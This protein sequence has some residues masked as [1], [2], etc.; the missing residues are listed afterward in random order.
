MKRLQL[1]FLLLLA[2]PIGMLAQSSNKDNEPNGTWQQASEIT[3]GSTVTGRL[4]DN[5]DN[6][7]WYKIVVPDE[8]IV[9]FKQHSETNL[10]LG[11]LYVEALDS[12]GELHT[13]GSHDMD[14]RGEDKDVEFSINDMAPGT[15]YI[16]QRHYTGNGS[17]QLTYTF[18]PNALQADKEPND[19][20]EKGDLLTSGKMVEGR[21]GYYYYND[22]D[23]VDCYKIVVPDEGIVTI[24]QHSE[25][26]LR[27]GTLY[28][29]ALDNGG[30][31]HT[32][33]SHD[34]DGRGEDKDV[35]FSIN[36]MAPGTYY[37]TQKHYTGY[38]GYQLTYTFTPNAHGA[39]VTGNDSYDKAS[40][41]ESGI[42][43]QGRLGYYYH[44]D[45]DNTDWYRIEVPYPSEAIFSTKT[46][47]T[48]RLGTMYVNAL[49]TDG[50]LRSHGSKDMDG[51]GEDT[52]IVNTISDL[53]AG[54]YYI[55]LKR[56]TGYGGYML[57]YQ[58]RPNNYGRDN[59]NNTSFS[60][61]MTLKE[62]T[63][64]NNTLGYYYYDDTNTEDWYDLGMI[65]SK[66][67]DVTISPE[68]SR[69]L[70][71]STCYIYKY[72]GDNSDGSPKLE[73]VASARLERS[74][75]TLSYIDKETT[76]SHY[77]V[78]VVRYN[79]FGGYSICYGKSGGESEAGAGGSNI[80]VMTGGHNTVRKGVPC[81]NPITISNLSDQPSD[82]FMLAID[83][84]DNINIIGFKM[85]V[86]NS[87]IYLP[88]DSVTIPDDKMCVFFVPRLEPWESYTF[89]LISEGVGDIAYAPQHIGIQSIGSKRIVIAGT[90]ITV[91]AIGAFAK[92]AAIS[93]AVGAAVDWVSKKAGDAIF[94]ADSEDAQN[95]ARLMGTTT[96]QLGIRS[97]W[98]SPTVYTAKSVLSTATTEYTKKIV[99]KT[100]TVLDVVGNVITAL[101]NIIPNLR[102][103]IWSWI[104]KDLG[105]YDNPSV[106]D[107]KNA[108]TDVVSSWDPNEMVGPAGAGDNHY[109]GKTQTI[110]YR[111][112]FENKAEA[113]APAY[114]VRINDEL[115]EKV[116]DVS[117]VKFGGTSH[118]GVGYNWKMTREGNRITWDIEGIEL[119]PNVNA[120]E[121]EGYVSFS[122]DLKSGLKD[123]TQIKNKATIIFDKNSPIETNEYVNILD[124][125][126]PTTTMNLA[127]VQESNTAHITCKSSD[128]GSGVDYYL[129]FAA[130]GNG[131]YEYQGQYFT[132]EMDCTVDGNPA[133]YSFYALAVDAVGNMEKTAPQAITPTGIQIIS[134]NKIPKLKVYSLDGRYVGKSLIG[135]PK[136]VY[137][138][139][140]KKV[141]K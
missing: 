102:R 44:N 112:L 107:G 62:G 109:L 6:V 50:N 118:E 111:I 76:A 34:M 3:N 29:D 16:M 136:G 40:T 131:E 25:T 130:K 35:E 115:D 83:C 57:N 105:Y 117:S 15:Y 138:I 68:L 97:S 26:T 96:K 123:G 39:D 114:R 2:L 53:A 36:D 119:P 127:N 79:G 61:R 120:P 137:V 10:R 77:V 82:F 135:S 4:G 129:L 54:T 21:L 95:Y 60:K 121:G 20:Y 89:T 23:R 41:L 98:D 18:T 24:K 8:G 56:Y 78:K 85:P 12:G 14:G 27:L 94:P 101:N 93:L 141:I 63:I 47:K 73:S 51:R 58:L 122:V 106:L 126:A 132:E 33:G 19:T 70:N 75:G 65:S 104:Y 66:Q 74:E 43:Q 32:H 90:V 17:Y 92:T 88:V 9:T 64:V 103:R 100:G 81:E 31:L 55:E 5:G 28:V 52:T 67:I 7:D 140:G 45:T 113:G 91:A 116:F 134:G 133:D 11:T 42:T 69:S 110:N 124:L 87:T 86:G 71:L 13:H 46:E 72:K 108:V 30:E 80:S 99:P 1:L 84:T 48:L 38:G 37:F 59:H 125:E 49:D 128:S 139:N 22:Q